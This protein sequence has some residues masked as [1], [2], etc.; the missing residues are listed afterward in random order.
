MSLDPA[1][2][3]WRTCDGCGVRFWCE[4]NSWLCMECEDLDRCA[5]CGA[6]VVEWGSED[7]RGNVTCRACIEQR[8]EES[9]YR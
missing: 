6:P 9:G 5:E 1:L 3:I 4:D 7:E 8:R 2:G